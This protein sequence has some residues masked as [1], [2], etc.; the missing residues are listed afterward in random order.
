MFA[1]K[2][3]EVGHLML[4]ASAEVVALKLLIGS[5]DLACLNNFRNLVHIVKEKVKCLFWPYY[6]ARNSQ[7]TPGM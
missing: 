7:N 6:T 3:V 2:V 5:L 1:G 4:A